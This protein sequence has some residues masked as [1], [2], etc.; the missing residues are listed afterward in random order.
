VVSRAALRAAPHP[1]SFGGGKDGMALAQIN[2]KRTAWWLAGTLGA[3]VLV[4]VGW[5]PTAAYVVA[6]FWGHGAPLHGAPLSYAPLRGASLIGA[7]LTGA[8]L[9]SADLRGADLAVADLRNAHLEGADLTS[10]N[11]LG[12]NLEGANL[13]GTNFTRANFNA[14]SIGEGL[15]DRRTRWP[16]GFNPRVFTSMKFVK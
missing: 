4:M 5:R 3:G 10:A 2:L 16:V 12:A 1:Y 11:L 8:H 13:Q 6:R 14:T 7:D 15:Y 9:V